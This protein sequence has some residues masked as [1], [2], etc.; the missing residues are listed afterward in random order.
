[1]QKLERENS[2]C[3]LIF[4]QQI[5]TTIP[6]GYKNKSIMGIFQLETVI[7]EAKPKQL[8]IKQYCTTTLI[9]PDH[10]IYQMI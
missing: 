3:C 9:L 7:P 2:I 8:D 6:W 1:M 4:E 10:I 5:F